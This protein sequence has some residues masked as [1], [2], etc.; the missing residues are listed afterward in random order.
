[1]GSRRFQ[2]VF[3]RHPTGGMGDYM[4]GVVE[5]QSKR[6][7][8]GVTVTALSYDYSLY[9]AT[10]QQY[11]TYLFP[12]WNPLVMVFEACYIIPGFINGFAAVNGLFS[13]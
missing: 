7:A 2:Y 3:W 8:M 12:G 5:R 11:S 6:H 10:C 4:V 1:M 13:L 9:I